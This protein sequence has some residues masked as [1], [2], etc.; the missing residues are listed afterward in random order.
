MNVTLSYFLRLAMPGCSGSSIF[1]LR[2]PPKQL[3]LAHLTTSICSLTFSSMQYMLSFSHITQVH[4]FAASVHVF[5]LTLLTTSTCSLSQ[6]LDC[7]T[8]SLSL[9][10]LKNMLS[11]F[12]TVCSLLYVNLL[13][14][15]ARVHTVLC[16]ICPLD[17]LFLAV[18]FS[19][20]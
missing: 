16:S 14:F 10:E 12:L 9:T 7:R 11:H 8:C 5:H 3:P 18:F 6:F 15:S 1:E 20:F 4:S 19:S 2:I 13:T 17:I